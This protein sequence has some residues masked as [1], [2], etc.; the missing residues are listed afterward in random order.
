MI[1][2]AIKPVTKDKDEDSMIISID[3]NIHILNESASW[4]Y[5]IISD[6]DLELSI[7]IDELKQKYN[8]I[9]ELEYNQ[10]ISDFIEFIIQLE[11]A[12]IVQFIY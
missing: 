12:G 8:D 7:I 9:W 2:H 11:K 5:E 3:K 10:I 6:K 1:I 4:I